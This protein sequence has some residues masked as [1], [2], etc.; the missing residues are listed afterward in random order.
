MM[1]QQY[2]PP[3]YV[4]QQPAKQGNGF[5]VTA[6]VLGIIGLVVSVIPILGFL[7]FVLGPLALIF[8]L[9]GVL[10]SNRPK[11][12][13]IT[14]MV[15]GVISVILAAVVASAFFSALTPPSEGA[16]PSQAI[17]SGS[18][19]GSAETPE[20]VEVIAVEAAQLL[21]EFEANEA[22]GDQTYAGRI[23]EVTGTV[24]GVDTELID[25]TKYIVQLD[26]GSEFSFTSVNCTDVPTDQA[27][28]AVAGSTVTIRG[29][30]E[31]GGSLGVNLMDCV[32]L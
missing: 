6:L 16:R 11:G 22:A 24:R 21:E 25:D 5:G 19:S 9:V 1:A 12:M 27:V 3:Q 31:D 14:G 10:Q 17:P 30:F 15:L 13:A 23:L 8:G 20:A 26:D 28:A 32:V 4:Q 29:M 18:P 7:A 2:Y